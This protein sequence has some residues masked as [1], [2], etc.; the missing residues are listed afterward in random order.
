M[1]SV[2]FFIILIAVLLTTFEGYGQAQLENKVIAALLAK[3]N[4]FVPGY[5]LSKQKGRIKTFNHHKYLNFVLLNVTQSSVLDATFDTASMFERKVLLGKDR[6]MLKDFCEKNDTSLKIDY[7]FGKE[8]G[9]TYLRNNDLK[10]IFSKEN[11]WHLYY[12]K[13]ELKP[14]VKVSRPGFN[15]KKNKAF[16]YLT[17]SLGKNDGAG[18][19]LVM[20]KSW[21]KWKPKGNMLVWIL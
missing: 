2:R 8:T 12:K 9:I 13:Y 10:K 15:K 5:K 16:I 11:D 17:Y 14:L 7:G 18:Y 21:G 19:Y 6:D 1:R 4:N 3:G 20:K